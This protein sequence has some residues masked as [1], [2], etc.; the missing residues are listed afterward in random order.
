MFARRSLSTGQRVRILIE[1]KLFEKKAF[2]MALEGLFRQMYV[3]L[4]SPDFSN[5]MK[6]F[7]FDL[8]DYISIKH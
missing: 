3:V 7:M 4:K 1:I 2:Q 6:F 8:Y 5:T